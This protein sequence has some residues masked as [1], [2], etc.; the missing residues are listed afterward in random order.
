MTT[1]TTTEAPTEAPAAAVVSDKDRAKAQSAIG[2]IGTWSEWVGEHVD[3]FF[4]EM[5]DQARTALEVVKPSIRSARTAWAKAE[6]KTED[7][8]TI[9]D[10]VSGL[11]MASGTWEPQPDDVARLSILFTLVVNDHSASTMAQYLKV[12]SHDVSGTYGVR[13]I[14]DYLDWLPKRGDYENGVLTQ[15]A[16]DRDAKAKADRLAKVGR[17]TLFTLTTHDFSTLVTTEAQPDKAA[18][19]KSYFALAHDLLAYAESQ[20]ADL[21]EGEADKI[22]RAVNKL[23]RD[24]ATPKAAKV[25][26]K[27]K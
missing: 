17:E 21:P 3:R 26:R 4:A 7:K 18:R 23:V 8:F 15:A 9:D 10:Y 12:V 5:L 11:A 20:A 16:I 6:G 1:T 19:V 13:Q 24:G 25:S 2:A 27:A 22:R 14:D